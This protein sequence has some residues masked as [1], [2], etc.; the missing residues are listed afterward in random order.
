MHE[1]EIAEIKHYLDELVAKGAT[2]GDK[3]SLAS[4]L[5]IVRHRRLMKHFRDTVR[6]L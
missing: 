6:P 2:M 5:A 4:I 3:K 1:A